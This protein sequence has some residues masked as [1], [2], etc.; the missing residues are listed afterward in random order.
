MKLLATEEHPAVGARPKGAGMAM[1]AAEPETVVTA[2]NA[3]HAGVAVRVGDGFH[4]NEKPFAS[5]LILVLQTQL[6]TDFSRA[7]F[8]AKLLGALIDFP[9]G[10]TILE[11]KFSNGNNYEVHLGFL[12]CRRKGGLAKN[13]LATVIDMEAV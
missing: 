2:L 5:R 9:S 11:T 7:Q 4:P 12:G 3:E 10:G 1:V 6:R 13:V 8:Q